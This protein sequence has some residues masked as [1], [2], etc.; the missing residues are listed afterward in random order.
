MVWRQTSRGRGMGAPPRGSSGRA[1][2]VVSRDERSEELGIY[3]GCRSVDGV[4]REDSVDGLVVPVVVLVRVQSR[5]SNFFKIPK[6][7]P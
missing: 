1:D 2:G 5:A 7:V 4:D 6:Y 3:V